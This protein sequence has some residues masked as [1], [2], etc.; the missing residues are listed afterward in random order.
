[1]KI[2]CEVGESTELTYEGFCGD[3]DEPLSSAT[4]ESYKLLKQPTKGSRGCTMVLHSVLVD[5]LV[6]QL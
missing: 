5:H 2:R 3:G 4:R 1:M 6:R